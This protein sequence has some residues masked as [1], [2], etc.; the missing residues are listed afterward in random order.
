M[1][2][3]EYTTKLEA[4][5]KAWDD[6][7]NKGLSAEGEPVFLVPKSRSARIFLPD[8]QELLEMIHKMSEGTPIGGFAFNALKGHKAAAH[9]LQL[10]LAAYK[11]AIEVA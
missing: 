7:I 3:D 2:V 1:T 8:P 5:K 11:C 6:V 9:N 10:V 4:L